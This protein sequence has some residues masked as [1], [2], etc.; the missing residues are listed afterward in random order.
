MQISL[1]YQFLAT[2]SSLALED[3]S[4]ESTLFFLVFLID[5]QQLVFLQPGLDH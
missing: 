2:L 4:L 1:L 3:N 5:Q